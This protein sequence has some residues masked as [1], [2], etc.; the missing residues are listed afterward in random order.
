MC[1]VC[2]VELIFCVFLALSFNGTCLQCI[3]GQEGKEND[4][5][6][7]KSLSAPPGPLNILIR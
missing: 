5:P 1:I 3:C 2:V 4:I 6:L 7:H